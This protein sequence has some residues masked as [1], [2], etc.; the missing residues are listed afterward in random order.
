MDKISNIITYIMTGL[1]VLCMTVLLIR[2]VVIFIK[3]HINKN[4]SDETKSTWNCNMVISVFAAG[5]VY[6]LFQF[7]K[8]FKS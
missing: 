7:L 2:N 1:L 8:F 3:V 4:S 5:L 6:E